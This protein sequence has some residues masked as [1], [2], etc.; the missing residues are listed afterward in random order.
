MNHYQYSIIDNM[1]D[2]KFKFNF[3]QFIGNEINDLMKNKVNRAKNSN[4]LNLLYQIMYHIIYIL[5]S[6]QARGLRVSRLTHWLLH[7]RLLSRSSTTFTN[8]KHV[9]IRKTTVKS[10]L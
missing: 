8:S 6:G 2:H 9:L 1:K 4:K 3:E 5:V 10:K 7:S